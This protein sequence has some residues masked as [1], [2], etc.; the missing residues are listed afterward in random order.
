MKL[1][2]IKE[3]NNHERRVVVTCNYVKNYISHGKQ[4]FSKTCCYARS[5]FLLKIM[6]ALVS[7]RTLS[8]ESE[9]YNKI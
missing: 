1:D 4:D 9:S 2:S 8:R 3:S 7:F 6:K 5:G